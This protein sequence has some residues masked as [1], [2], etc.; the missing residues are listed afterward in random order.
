[1]REH[2]MRI[3]SVF[4]HPWMLLYLSRV[5]GVGLYRKS[6]LKSFQHLHPLL[7]S[8]RH[9][10]TQPL[11]LVTLHQKALRQTTLPHFSQY[12]AT[13]GSFN[14]AR[15]GAHTSGTGTREAAALN[16]QAQGWWRSLSTSYILRISALQPV[17]RM[18]SKCQNPAEAVTMLASQEAHDLPRHR[19]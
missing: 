9:T 3:V 4:P 15:R 6:T 2:S 12:K 19:E 14:L 8:T 1:M 18:S 5:L 10:F 17:A 11:A 13:A 7:F 16:K